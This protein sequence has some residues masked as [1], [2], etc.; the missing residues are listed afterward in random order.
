MNLMSLSNVAPFEPLRYNLVIYKET[1]AHGDVSPHSRAHAYRRRAGRAEL[2]PTGG[3]RLPSS[4]LQEEGASRAHAYRRRAG[5]AKDPAR[6]RQGENTPGAA[7]GTGLP[8]DTRLPRV[9]GAPGRVEA[10]RSATVK[11]GGAAG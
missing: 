11:D 9:P 2:T 4:R 3:G 10:R 5:R 8:L 7:H 6:G 1:R